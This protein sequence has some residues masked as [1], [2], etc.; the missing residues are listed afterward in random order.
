MKDTSFS[1]IVS[2]CTPGILGSALMPA[3][4][5]ALLL[6]LACLAGCGGGI[7]QQDMM[8]MSRRRVKKDE[9]DEKPKV[10]QQSTPPQVK[11]AK[12][13]AVPAP[14][15]V[16]KSS[17]K[18]PSQSNPP[19]SKN[20]PPQSTEDVASDT[21]SKPAQPLAFVERSQLSA[22]NLDRIAQALEAYLQDNG[23]YPA[24]AIYDGAKTPLLSWRVELLPYLG[25]QDLYDAFDRSKPWNSP[26]NKPLLK[27]I[28]AVYQSPERF[29][30]RTNYL[31]AVGGGTLFPGP[32][33]LNLRRV[34]DG[35]EHTALV[36]EANDTLSAAWTK[37]QEYRFS[38]RKPKLGLGRL[39][40]N[41]VF[42]IWGGGVTGAV[43]ASLANQSFKAMFTVDGGESFSSYTASLP[44][45]EDF[46]TQLATDPNQAIAASPVTAN[47]SSGAKK[48]RSRLAAGAVRPVG[49]SQG[50][51]SEYQKAAQTNYAMNQP[52]DAL[53][54]YYASN[55]MQPAGARWDASYRWVPALQRPSP[56]IHFC[57]GVRGSNERLRKSR[58]R[59]LKSNRQSKRNEVLGQIAGVGQQLLEII[60]KHALSLVPRSLVGAELSESRAVESGRKNVHQEPV[61]PVSYLGQGSRA[62]LTTAATALAGDVLVLFEVK[63]NSAGSALWL[64]CDLIDLARGKKILSIPRIH[65]QADTTLAALERDEAY[66]KKRWQLE[67]ALEDS[68]SFQDWPDGLKPRHAVARVEKLAE[69]KTFNTLMALAEMSVYRNR[70][71]IDTQHLLQGFRSLLGSDAGEALMLGSDKKRKRVLRNWLPTI[72]PNELP[73]VAQRRRQA[74]EGED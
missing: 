33:T 15:T 63:V 19:N 41:H 16:S 43:P 56:T 53:L 40:Q 45:D 47:A 68:L 35:I 64:T 52:S 20:D 31:L 54:W 39:R 9:E 1:R 23:L 7:S 37:P 6:V 61:L 49:A 11:E 48:D 57:V 26:A 74:K 17:P 14:Q 60:E 46:F 70:Q 12:E 22:E 10:T 72:D 27:K 42:V 44:I 67:D 71:L 25:Y 66:K 55:L 8:R 34:E 30:T 36:V 29:D 3:R 62:E 59:T 21:K 18:R 69:L 13:A 2:R 28:P 24:Q 58:S 4:Y 50:L 51:A 65:W 32:R 38:A 73:Q 5:L